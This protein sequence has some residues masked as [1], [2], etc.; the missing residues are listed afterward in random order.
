MRSNKGPHP[1]FIS[2]YSFLFDSPHRVLGLFWPADMV[3]DEVI[4]EDMI[5][6]VPIWRKQERKEDKN[7]KNAKI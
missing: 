7:V 3:M 6:A 5:Q 4:R 2:L 1:S